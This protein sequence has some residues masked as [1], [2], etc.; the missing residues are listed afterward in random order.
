[1]A[2][3]KKHIAV[4]L[5]PE[6]EAA[7]IAF[8]KQKG[9]KSKRGTMFSAGVNTALAEFFGIADLEGGNIPKGSGN[10]PAG[11]SNTRSQLHNIP[12][13]SGSNIPVFQL[14]TYQ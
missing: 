4:Y 9:L 2:T 7:L 12:T 11:V 14:V 1:M 8:C 5:P 6:I 10:K 3:E 13:R